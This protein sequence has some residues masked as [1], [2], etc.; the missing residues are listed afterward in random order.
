M[1]NNDRKPNNSDEIDLTQFFKWVGRGL[2]R[3]GNSIIYSIATLR[4]LFFSHL[5]FFSIVIISGLALATVYFQFLDKK[6]YKST[7]VLSCDYLNTQILANTIEKL[8]ILCGEPGGQGLAT[9]LNIDLE[10]ARS[11]Q[12]FEFKPFISE[13]DIVEIE[14]LKEQLTNLASDKKEITDRVIQKLEIQNKDAYQITALV[15]NPSMIKTLEVALVKYFQ[16]SDYIKRRVEINKVNL[17][18][19][20]NKLMAESKKLDSLKKAI[21]GNIQS[22]SKT[23]GASNNLIMTEEA[24]NRPLEIFTEDL[25]INAEI[26]RIDEKLYLQPDFEVI[27]AFTT[28]NQPESAGLLQLL[29][30]SFFISLISGYLILGAWK[31]DRMLASYPIKT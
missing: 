17:T 22:F 23:G 8:N 30:I 29:G 21:I 9:E 19:R 31:F 28:F 10:T 13:N 11:I 1:E 14:V 2:N 12:K 16:E 27:E 3:F 24:L 25:R 5:L 15:Y 26:L 20:K 7:M 18:N 4:Q 6:Y